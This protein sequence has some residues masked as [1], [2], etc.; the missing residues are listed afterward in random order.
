MELALKPSLM[1]NCRCRR[2]EETYER[3]NGVTLQVTNFI[4]SWPE[5]LVLWLDRRIAVPGLSGRISYTRSDAPV[6]LGKTLQVHDSPVY[7][8]RAMVMHAGTMENDDA[9][10]VH[11]YCTACCRAEDGGWFEVHGAQIPRALSEDDLFYRGHRN[12]VI[13]FYERTN[14][15]HQLSEFL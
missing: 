15:E 4:A 8:L 11:A 12:V 6:W 10:D 3:V 5:V 9:R 2:C 1:L 13:M 7:S 14:A